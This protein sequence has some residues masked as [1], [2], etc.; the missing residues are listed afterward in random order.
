M[1]KDSLNKIKSAET[2]AK[3]NLLKAKEDVNLILENAQ[4]DKIVKIKEFD[5]ELKEKNVEFLKDTEIK[6]NE[7]RVT[8]SKDTKKY[9]DAIENIADRN[10]QQ[11]VM[12]VLELI[13]N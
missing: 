5:Q 9:V 13:L 12:S 4:K 3:E 8:I 10:E 7:I 6:A 11:A 2:L 1:A